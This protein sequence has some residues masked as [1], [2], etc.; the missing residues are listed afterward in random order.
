MTPDEIHAWIRT[1]WERQTPVVP[2]ACPPGIEK[3]DWKNRHRVSAK[4]R[5][6]NYRL[7]MAFCRD[8]EYSA[9]TGINQIFSYFFFILNNDTANS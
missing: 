6:E 4:L 9:N 1:N 7:F 8:N 3:D 5:P 2:E